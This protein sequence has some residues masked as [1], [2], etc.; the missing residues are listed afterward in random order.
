MGERLADKEKHKALDRQK[1]CGWEQADSREVQTAA[2][3]PAADVS[4]PFRLPVSLKALQECGWGPWCTAALGA[5]IFLR[6]LPQPSSS[7]CLPS[8]LPYL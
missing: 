7:R 2:R 8:C 4:K 6:V 5:V 3:P 1:Y